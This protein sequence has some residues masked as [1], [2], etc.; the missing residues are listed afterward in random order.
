[1]AVFK[2]VVRF[3]R[4]DGFY[5]VYIRV[6]H[7]RKAQYI[8]TDK[9]VDQKG[10]DKSN[11]I[12]DPYVMK[13]CANKISRFV[14]ILNKQDISSWT[15]DEVVNYLKSGTADICFSDYAR[16]YQSKM[17]QEG[18]ARNARTYELAYHL[19]IRNTLLPRKLLLR[20]KRN[21]L[22][23]NKLGVTSLKIRTYALFL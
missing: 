3:K 2:A 7:Q 23:V 6:T 20:N 8:K 18:H 22:N 13:Y 11:G 17:I 9:M 16:E 15:V 14:E 19:Q 5:P 21:V 4:P 12:K 10:V 1:M